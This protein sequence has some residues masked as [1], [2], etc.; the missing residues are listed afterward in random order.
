MDPTWHL[1]PGGLPYR[2]A[3]PAQLPCGPLPLVVAVH[4]YTRQPQPLWDAF[5]R[6]V[7]GRGAALLLPCFGTAAFRQFQQL[8]RPRRPDDPQRADLALIDAVEH[9]AARTGLR[10]APW[11]LF[12][13]SGGAQFAHR[14]ALAHPE[15][16]AAV[17]LSAAGWYTMPMASL[18]YPHGLAGIDRWLGHAPGLDR[19]LQLPIRAWVGSRDRGAQALL[20]R[21]PSLDAWQGTTRVQR[22]Q[23]WVSAVRECA[24]AYG[25]RA[26][27]DLRILPGAGHEFDGCVRAGLVPA[28]LTFFEEAARGPTRPRAACV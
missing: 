20:R 10:F 23:R 18:P 8:L 17:A 9:L 7:V 5:A 11:H 14:F 2:V 12:G 26:R 6:P 1:A 28:V 24:G 21:D 4:G 13:H 19:F 25:R 27:V 15:R 22:A 3:L 16:L